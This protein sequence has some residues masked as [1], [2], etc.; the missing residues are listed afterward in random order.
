[1][2]TIIETK[3]IKYFLGVVLI[4]LSVSAGCSRSGAIGGLVPCEG[5]VT[6]N[7]QPF[8]GATISFSPEGDDNNNARSA[9]AIIDKNGHY[10]I[11]TSSKD[12]GILPGNYKVT[13]SKRVFATEAD[14]KLAEEI[15]EANKQKQEEAKKNKT[16][17]KPDPRSR[18][19][20]HKDLA[21]KYANKNT[22]ELTVTITA[23]GNKNLDF[24][25]EVHE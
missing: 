23:E 24:N 1:M 9:G 15:K 10:K 14:A 6:L 7:G 20:K 5:I 2:K 25:I 17:P 16:R 12:I 22:S 19:I 8:D 13:L 4:F 3:M 21:G 18:N 11:Q